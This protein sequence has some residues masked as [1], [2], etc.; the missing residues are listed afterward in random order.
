MQKRLQ[1]FSAL[2]MMLT[3]FFIPPT[4]HAQ[5]TCDTPPAPFDDPAVLENWQTIWDLMD[6]CISQ[7]GVFNEV[8]SGGVGRDGI[9][10]IDDP[11]FDTFDIADIWLQD[12]SPVISVEVDGIARAYP[13]AI[14]TR[15]EIVNDVIGETPIAA[16]FCPLCNSAIVFDRRVEG[17]VLRLGVSGFLRKSDLIMWDDKTQS[18]W[19]Q[20]TGEGLV[21]TYTGTLLDIIPSQVVGYG[22][23]KAQYP[24]GEVLSTNGRNYGTNPY[25]SYDSNSQ[26]FLFSGTPDT[27]L[28]PT[29]R[30][31]GA[32]INDVTIAY[33]FENLAEEIAINDT[34]ADVDVVALWQPGK[35]SALDQL[36]ID[37]SRDVGMAG[38]FERDLDGQTL[39]FSVNNGAI[40]DDQT[41]SSWNIFGTATAGDLVGSQ[42]TQINAFPHFWF[43]WASFH[44]STEIY[45]YEPPNAEETSRY[46]LDPIYGNPDAPITLI[47]YGAYGCHACKF[48]HEEGLIEQVIEEFDGQVNFIFRDAP[49]ISPQYDQRAAEIAQCALDQG[50]DAFWTYHDAV[51]TI[52]R[53]GISSADDLIEIGRQAGLDSDALR[54]CYEA[55]THVETV[56]YDANRA[57]QL[58]VRGTPTFFIGDQLVFNASP[59]VLRGL[60]QAELN[61]LGG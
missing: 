40:V 2:V 13:L 4:S 52:A 43:A 15:H 55:G 60:I 39:T 37:A 53:Q 58:G 36:E 17:D 29:S 54:S 20:F 5:L 61:A 34:I 14:L 10:P 42:L 38:L 7:P 33:P 41:G 1:L 45:G 32:D 35:A 3:V 47:E 51:F 19:Q 27:R 48:W 24:D 18:W 23:F 59:D 46:D 30:I 22:A 57:S 56:R 12:Q 6:L 8:L 49:I 16:T 28:F 50:N 31:L 11:T 9:P 21:G 26:P 44:P 25:V